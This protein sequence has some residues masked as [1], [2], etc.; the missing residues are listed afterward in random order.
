MKHEVICRSK[1][2]PGYLPEG[3]ELV[4][5]TSRSNGIFSTLSPFFAGPVELYGGH[6]AKNVENAW[7]YSKLYKEFADAGGNPTEEYFKW[8]ERGW[9]KETADRHPMGRS[10]PLCSIWDGEKLG[11]VEAR[12]R[13][14]IPLYAEAV[15]KTEG[16]AELKKRYEDGAKLC[17]LDFDGWNHQK[18][19]YNANDIANDE[20]RRMGH[21]FVLKFLLEGTLDSI[22]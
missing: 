21:C 18:L 10:K 15:I 22:K 11:Y 8:A 19:G 5:V 20:T 12:K 9:A 6:V 13:I 7:Q 2:N 14:Y 1:R 4:D 17:L 3:Y 16:F